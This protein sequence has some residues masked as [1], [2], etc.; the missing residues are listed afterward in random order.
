MKAVATTEAMKNFSAAS[1][2]SRPRRSATSANAGSD[3]VSIDT[4]SVIRSSEAATPSAPVAELSSRKQNS[5]AGRSPDAQRRP[6]Q[7][8]HEPVATD[9]DQ[10]PGRA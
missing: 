9:D 10:P 7:Q 5:P 8:Q 2:P 1:A 6:R 3:T 4:T